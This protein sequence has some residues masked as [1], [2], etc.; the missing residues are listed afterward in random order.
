MAV[1]VIL[2]G[3]LSRRFQRPGE[4]W[5]NKCLYPVE[6]RPM[7]YRV[8][9]AARDLVSRIYVAPGR[10]KIEGFPSIDDDP[11]FS[12]PVAAVASAVAGLSDTLLFAPCDVPFISRE[13]FAA[14]LEQKGTAVFVAPNGLVESHIF[15][16]EP[17]DLK[18]VLPFL[19]RRGGR[20][21][22]IFRLSSSVTYLSVVEHSIPPRAL[23]NI[24]F[25]EDLSTDE[26]SYAEV[27]TR[28]LR[29]EWEPPLLK[30][31]KGGSREVL[32]EELRVYLENGLFSMAAH[33]IDDLAVDNKRLKLISEGIKRA[34][35]LKKASL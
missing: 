18:N 11:E 7:I 28:D 25:R 19:R 27:F 33:V 31:I 35:G 10:N 22:D 23:K 6:G 5:V 2:A 14:L 15:K 24:N 20:L 8:A 30:Y 12:G 29:I 32:W 9:D 17:A 3:G 21:D 1:L 4:P 13:V 16:A 34:V 26:E